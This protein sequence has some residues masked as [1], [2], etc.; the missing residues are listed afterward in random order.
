MALIRKFC[1]AVLLFV[2]ELVGDGFVHG[3][4]D[5]QLREKF[6]NHNQTLEIF[7]NDSATVLIKPLVSFLQLIHVMENFLPVGR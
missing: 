3:D 2:Y 1:Y 7:T 6:L 5:L 4:D